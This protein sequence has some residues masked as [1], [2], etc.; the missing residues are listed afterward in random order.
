MIYGVKSS[1]NQAECCLRKTATLLES[2][3][4][5]ASEIV[6]KDIGG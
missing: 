4:A 5:R 1:G 2:K 3:Y 6:D